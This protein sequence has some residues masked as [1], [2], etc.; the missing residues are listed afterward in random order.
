LATYDSEV[1]I[2]LI[3]FKILHDTGME[4]FYANMIAKFEYDYTVAFF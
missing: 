3:A 2:M 1:Q 4:K